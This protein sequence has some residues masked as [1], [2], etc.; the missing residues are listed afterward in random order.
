MEAEL[1]VR[2]AA[3]VAFLAVPA[4]AATL[5]VLLE[6]WVFPMPASRRW[7]AAWCLASLTAA[8]LAASGHSARRATGVGLMVVPVAIGIIGF[9]NSLES[10][11]TRGTVAPPQSPYRLSGQYSRALL[12]DIGYMGSGFLLWSGWRPGD[13]M[14][15]V[16]RRLRDV[17][18]RITG[19]REGQSALLGYAW[20]PVLLGGAYLMDWVINN[21]V[22]AVV[23]GDDSRVWSLMT[24]YHA[25]MLA[26]AAAVTEE[27][28]YRLLI[29]G[30]TAHVLQSRGLR[31]APA[32]AVAMV[33]QA[34]VFGMTHGG[35]GDLQI[36][37][38]ASA[39]AVLAGLA[40]ILLGIWAAI[41]LH[42]LIDF[43]VFGSY[44]AA[45]S[46]AMLAVLWVLLAVNVA[47][48]AVV[49]WNAWREHAG[50]ASIGARGET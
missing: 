16:A 21:H 7:L 32:L 48:A 39:F 27:L 31:P 19:R 14:R 34:L 4:I 45:D 28:L 35:Y 6:G 22:P 43:F 15:T 47:V 26:A 23:T 1:S 42:F 50:G 13:G 38:Q 36:I 29:L 46:P 10:V 3:T 11:I 18:P 30:G 49:V 2:R 20:F 25:L 8:S 24:P 41:V 5:H 9:I 44:V 33:V 37:L 40:A 12:V 17:A